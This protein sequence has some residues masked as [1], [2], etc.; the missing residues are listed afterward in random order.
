MKL[1]LQ[2]WIILLSIS[3]AKAQNSVYPNAPYTTL[4]YID[5]EGD[6][7]YCA[8][9]CDILTYSTDG[10]STWTYTEAQIYGLNDLKIIPNTNGQKA[11]LTYDGALKVFDV[12]DQSLTVINDDFLN[13]YSDNFE[14]SFFIADSVYT[15]NN[16][17]VFKSKIGTYSWETYFGFSLS[18]SFIMDVDMTEN[19]FWIGT[20]TGDLLKINIKDKSIENIYTFEKRVY[21]VE[22]V[23]DTLGYVEYQTGSNIQ[24]TTNGGESFV[25]LTGMPENINPLALGENILFTINTNRV[26]LSQ[27]GGNTSKYIGNPEDGQSALTYGYI[28]T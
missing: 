27:D 17:G 13:S 1:L 23:N 15:I 5:V 11:L 12:A 25:P 14:K 7:I 3:I 21:D 10:G 9:Y 2:I 22:M 8:G 26:Y 6:N 18:S 20:S 24:K 28:L 19:Y 4:R 16:V